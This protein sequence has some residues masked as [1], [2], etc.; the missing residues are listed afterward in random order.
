M[1]SLPSQKQLSTLHNKIKNR[2]Y[3]GKT[4]EGESVD[5]G[6]D[7]VESSC[8]ASGV[9]ITRKQKRVED[10]KTPYAKNAESVSYSEPLMLAH[11]QLIRSRDYIYRNAED[12]NRCQR[13]HE[14]LVRHIARTYLPALAVFQE[15]YPI[16]ALE[17][18]QETLL[19]RLANGWSMG[20]APDTDPE[21]DRLAETFERVLTEYEIVTDALAGDVMRRYT[22]DLEP[23]AGA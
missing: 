4:I 15:S 8:I 12:P 3:K 1:T 23:M 6:T 21:T 17:A 7:R 18:E 14:R 13:G 5:E 2:N 20:E 22:L 10:A 16:E 19:T 11:A 9:Q